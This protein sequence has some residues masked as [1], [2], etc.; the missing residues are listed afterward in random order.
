[1]VQLYYVN[2]NKK[3]NYW[4]KPQKAICQLKSYELLHKLTVQKLHLRKFTIGK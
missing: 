4:E 3:I 1:M 2:N